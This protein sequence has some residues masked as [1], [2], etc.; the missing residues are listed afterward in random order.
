VVNRVAGVER[1]A[2]LTT[3]DSLELQRLFRQM[4]GGGDLSCVM[5][6]SSHALAL[7]RTTGITFESLIFTNLSRDH[8]DFH[9]SFEAYF[10]AKRSLFCP[11]SGDGR[12]RRPS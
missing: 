4:V 5:E 1:I 3:P 8:L 11:T 2:K 12:A 9:P 10:A 7:E 6:A